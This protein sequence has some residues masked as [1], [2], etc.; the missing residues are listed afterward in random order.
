MS[1]AEDVSTS[2]EC[3][4][5]CRCYYIPANENSMFVCRM[6]MSLTITRLMK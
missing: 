1:N 4:Q 6:K 3:G 2:H 5:K